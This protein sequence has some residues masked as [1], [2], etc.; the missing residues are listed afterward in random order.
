MPT[1]KN[2]IAMDEALHTAE[3]TNTASD[4]AV[5]AMVE[6]ELL[7]PSQDMPLLDTCQGCQEL[8]LRVQRLEKDLEAL[9]RPSPTPILGTTACYWITVA[10]HCLLLGTLGM[11]VEAVG[12]AVYPFIAGA[13]GS[14]AVCHVLPVRTIVHKFART[15]LSATIVSTC[16]LLPVWVTSGVEY[17][18]LIAFPLFYLPPAFLSAWFIAKLFVWIRGWKILPKGHDGT[19][20]MTSIWDLLTLTFIAAVYLAMC[21]LVLASDSIDMDTEENWYL[22][23][24]C[25]AAAIA[26][27]LTS[28]LTARGLLT[29]NGIRFRWLF[30]AAI[31]AF[32]IVGAMSTIALLTGDASVGDLLIF[33]ASFLPWSLAILVSPVIT[34][35]LM[36]VAGYRI[37]YPGFVRVETEFVP[38]REPLAESTG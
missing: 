19:V 2:K 4:E 15:C 16:L 18:S 37:S 20:P 22:V 3:P 7:D 34:F 38:P 21:R 30:G 1:W 12:F 11:A 10:A 8:K 17:A 5:L 33:M 29:E 26:G 27:S 32:S 25:L 24:V 28:I 36:R 35:A 6:P 9:K 13:I 23:A 31:Y 14:L